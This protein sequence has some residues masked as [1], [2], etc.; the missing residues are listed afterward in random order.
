MQKESTNN[1]PCNLLVHNDAKNWGWRNS[2]RFNEIVVIP[3]P[4]ANNAAQILRI[5]MHCPSLGSPIAVQETA[6]L[7]VD[8]LGA[9]ELNGAAGYTG[10]LEMVA[11]IHM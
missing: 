6:V 8:M 2:H 7:P 10:T 3:K 5:T 11:S 1:M 4:S 9:N